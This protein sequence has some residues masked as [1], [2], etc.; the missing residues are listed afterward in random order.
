MRRTR[1]VTTVLAVGALVLTG[2]GGDDSGG[3]EG[4][5]GATSESAATSSAAEDAVLATAETPSA[6]SWWTPR[7]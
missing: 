4:T 2:C 5:A 3:D 7:A 6:P 1:L